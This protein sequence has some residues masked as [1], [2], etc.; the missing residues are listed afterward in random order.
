MPGASL[1]REGLD[2][3]LAVLDADRQK[4]GEKYEEIRRRLVKLFECRGL[5][6]PEEAAD[7]TFDRVA[8]RLAEG[9]R[10]RAGEPAAYFYGVARN[11]LREGWRRQQE[12]PEADLAIPEPHAR[13]EDGPDDLETRLQCLERCLATL[14][15]EARRLVRAYYAQGPGWNAAARRELCASLG[16]SANAL[17]VRAHRLR[18]RLERCVAECVGRPDAR[19]HPGG[20]LND[21]G[22]A[23]A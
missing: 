21:E 4:A 2:D 8:R 19:N 22:G 13:P 3:L 10:I 15:P 1:T 17:W 14:A 5:L 11:V 23:E 7:E 9:E 6:R 20:S 18:A 12:R 16:I